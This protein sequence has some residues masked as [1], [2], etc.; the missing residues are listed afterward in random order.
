M[1]IKLIIASTRSKRFEF[2]RQE[3]FMN[4]NENHSQ[5]FLC[6]FIKIF[7]T[8]GKFVVL[9]FLLTVDLGKTTYDFVVL[10]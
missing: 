1:V 3:N 4:E 6:A 5:I 8:I 10:T 7:F 9:G 2:N